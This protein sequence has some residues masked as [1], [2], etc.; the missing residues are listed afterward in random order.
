MDSMFS[1]SDFGL[2]WVPLVPELSSLQGSSENE[3]NNSHDSSDVLRMNS[4]AEE[5][6]RYFCMN[7]CFFTSIVA[8]SRDQSGTSSLEHDLKQAKDVL[9][10]LQARRDDVQAGSISKEESLERL[11][12]SLNDPSGKFFP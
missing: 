10:R 1:M 9:V 12:Q 4:G 8:C 2:G 5:R 6:L 7:A 11:R 3:I